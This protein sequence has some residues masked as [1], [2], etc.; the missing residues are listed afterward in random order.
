M[1][2]MVGEIKMAYMV[3]ELTQ[4]VKK[5]LYWINKCLESSELSNEQKKVMR[6]YETHCRLKGIKP[7]SRCNY[8]K[9]LKVF[10]RS[11]KKDFDNV[12]DK[13]ILDYFANLKGKNNKELAEDTISN[14]QINAIVF[15]K[16]LGKKD[17]VDA[18]LKIKRK[19]RKNGFLSREDLPTKEELLKIIKEA[20]RLRDKALIFVL[21]ESAMRAHECL[22]LRIKDV[23]IYDNYAELTVRSSKTEQRIIP[24]IN[25][26]PLLKQWINEHPTGNMDDFLWISFKNGNKEYSKVR[27]TIDSLQK[28]LKEGAERS[29]IKKRIFPH[30]LRHMRT[31]ELLASGMNDSLVKKITGHSAD[32]TM[33]A[34]YGHLISDDAKNYLLNLEGLFDK[35]EKQKDDGLSVKICPRCQ[36]KNSATNIYCDKCWLAL[37][38]ETAMKE[39][40]D[41]E[42]FAVFMRDMKKELKGL[43]KKW[44]ENN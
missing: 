36:E 37:N 7:R 39:Q 21:Y 44:K 17:V 35:K 20:P 26:I 11:I 16:W 29:G 38:I 5:D 25:S 8:I 33:L 10:G 18:I 22:N 1:V 31:T 24:I 41:T 13:D 42:E 9:W 4:E 2:Y 30:L 23:K 28:L 14:Y 43:F 32:S 6:E 27:I 34:R 19:K 3:N 12:T 15:Y 40:E